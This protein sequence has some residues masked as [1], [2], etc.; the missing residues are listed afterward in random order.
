[1]I[2]TELEKLDKHRRP[3][4]PGKLVR[5]RHC[6]GPHGQTQLVE[7]RLREIDSYGGL[8]LVLTKPAVFYARDHRQ[9]RDIG[10]LFY[11]AIA[12]TINGAKQVFYHEHLDFEHAHQV[13]AE[14]I[15][16]N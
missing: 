16:A 4:A 6:V 8:T 7:G 5:V 11:V 13:W 3:L 15:E 9:H 2:A 10:D 12:T 1:M 14:V